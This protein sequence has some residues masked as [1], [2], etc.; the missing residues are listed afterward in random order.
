[1][2]QPEGIPSTA[3]PVPYYEGYFIDD[4]TQAVYST[5]KRGGG[6]WV[7]GDVAK[8]LK[9]K[10]TRRGYLQAALTQNGK[11]KY[12]GFHRLLLMSYKPNK[13][14][15]KL[16]AAHKDGD[17]LNNRLSN[18]YWATPK[19]NCQD[20]IEHGTHVSVWKDPKEFRRKFGEDN[21]KTSLKESQV[22]DIRVKAKTIPCA[23][24]AREYEVCWSTI[25]NIVVGRTWSHLPITG[26]Q[27]KGQIVLSD[28]DVRAI[29]EIYASG[30]VKQAQLAK[31]YSVHFATINDIIGCR[32]RFK[33]I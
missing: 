27:M 1:M 19:Q 25:K 16:H 7:I 29:R 22:M 5:K 21:P 17:S 33:H 9:L 10:L 8:E 4:D 3:V 26:H 12:I 11:T 28:D 31:L 30:A 18:L 15:K 20:A 32:R 14:Y 2:H 24:L 13:N 6:K 23:D